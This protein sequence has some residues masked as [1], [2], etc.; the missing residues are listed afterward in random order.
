MSYELWVMSNE[1]WV[2]E[3]VKPN[4]PL[5]HCYMSVALNPNPISTL[6]SFKKKYLKKKKKDDNP[7]ERVHEKARWQLLLSLGV[8]MNLVFS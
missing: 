3:K 1:N 4:S 2:I 7:G 5:V 6:H 8:L